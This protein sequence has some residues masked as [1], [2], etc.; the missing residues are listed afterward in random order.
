[1][2]SCLLLN[3]SFAKDKRHELDICTT[4]T[5]WVQFQTGQLDFLLLLTRTLT[6]CNRHSYKVLFARACSER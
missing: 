4:W 3:K 1:M 5:L 2:G 6:A